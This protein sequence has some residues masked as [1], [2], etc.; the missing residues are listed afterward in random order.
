VTV[1]M[2]HGDTVQGGQARPEGKA[3]SPSI[4][5]RGVEPESGLPLLGICYGIQFVAQLHQDGMLARGYL[6]GLPGVA[7]LRGLRYVRPWGAVTP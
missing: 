5:I 2:S 3:A 6:V 1:W 7:G 4:P